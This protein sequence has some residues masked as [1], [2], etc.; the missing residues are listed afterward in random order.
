MSSVSGYQVGLPTL[1]R[2]STIRPIPFDD[3]AFFVVLYLF[4]A[5]SPNVGRIFSACV[6]RTPPVKRER[7]TKYVEMG[8]ACLQLDTYISTVRITHR[9]ILHN[10]VGIAKF[11]QKPYKFSIFYHL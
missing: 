6:G 3:F 11:C 8:M 9:C 1:M 4:S 2:H 10:N 7:T 5:G